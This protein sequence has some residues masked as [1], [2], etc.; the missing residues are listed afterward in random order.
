MAGKR[1]T[2]EE[3]YE[4]N[5]GALK[6][7]VTDPDLW[8]QWLATVGNHPKESALNCAAIMASPYEDTREL[9]N[10][11]GWARFGG[12]VKEGEPGIP[13]V[14]RSKAGHLFCDILYPASA[15]EG[16]TR[17]AIA[18]CPLRSTSRTRSTA[19]PTSP[20]ARNG[21]RTLPKRGTRP[22]TP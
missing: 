14:H 15:V 8:A 17:S 6:G 2:T 9:R 10:A 22:C 4:S 13:T 7:A 21:A 12:S 18:G 11:E 19:R 16:R 20:R 5:L 3:I 1:I